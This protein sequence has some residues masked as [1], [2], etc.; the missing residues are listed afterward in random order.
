[1]LQL[2]TPPERP[3]PALLASIGI[4]VMAV[5]AFGFGPLL[6]F[7]DAP[8]WR[9]RGLGRHA[10]GPL[11]SFA[12][13]KAVDLRDRVPETRASR[14]SGGGGLP[15]ARRDGPPAGPVAPI[16]QPRLDPGRPSAP[17]RTPSRREIRASRAA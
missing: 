11:A 5:S 14:G 3:R 4:H 2:A 12:T 13:C 8:G 15:A 6:A 17:R 1:M 10:A 7:P 9:G 16:V